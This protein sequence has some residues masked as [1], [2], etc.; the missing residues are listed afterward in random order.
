MQIRKLTARYSFPSH[1]YTKNKQTN[2]HNKGV[3]FEQEQMRQSNFVDWGD[4]CHTYHFILRNL[5]S[6]QLHFIYGCN[7]FS[8][9]E[10][11]HV[12]KSHS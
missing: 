10:S 12:K 3:I 6:V 8:V 4:G 2:N 9:R 1:I 7:H 5:S 11:I